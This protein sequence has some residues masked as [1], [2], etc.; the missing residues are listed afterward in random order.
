MKRVLFSMLLAF[1]VTGLYAQ[2][3]DK[4]KDKLKEGKLDEA[5]SEVDAFLAIDKNQKN[6]DAWYTKAKVYNAIAA[7]D[8]SKADE[9]HA[10]AFDALKKYVQY[11]DKLLISLQIDKY[12]PLND[13]YGA[14]FKQGADNFNDKKYDV[15]YSGFKN[16]LE[17]SKYMAEK[18]W[19]TSKIDTT[20][21]LYAG[22]SAEK[23][24]K[25]D[26]AAVYYGQLA[27]NKITKYG[28]DDLVGI[29][30]W[31]ARHYADKK[32]TANANKYVALGRE[33][34]PKDTFWPSLELDMAK[35]GNDKNALFAK[36]EDVINRYPENHLFQYDYAYELYKYAYDTAKS[37]RPANSDELIAKAL[38]NVSGVIKIKPDYAQ[39]QLFAGQIIF[40]Q[41][42]DMLAES[43]KIK[44]T[45]P[46][47]VKKK[48]DLK[49]EAMK[50]FD[51]STP[52]FLQ[53]D[54]LLAGQGK[55]KMDEKQAL[56]EAYDLLIT[57]YD[58][59]NMK[60]KVKEYEVK[61][62]DVDRVH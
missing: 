10:I 25:P 56:K 28:G 34:F 62:N 60:D 41:G 46:E 4:A 22:V 24:E 15:S 14:Y 27:D 54:K 16:A 13:I 2:K 39:A 42:V 45:K 8:K 32:D 55:L 11:D 19:L 50:K 9:S 59:K 38:T 18:G 5:K 43:K 17:V 26:E 51:E 52:Y 20:S 6:A 40:N 58:Q 31:L 29:Y 44:G 36:Y 53:V 48:S 49:A 57:I 12:Q 3:L 30:Q 61:F 23:L 37:K 7:S 35:E 21:T 47:D 33:L 1:L